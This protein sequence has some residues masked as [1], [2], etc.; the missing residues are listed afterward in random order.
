MAN[1][2]MLSKSISTSVQ[3][4]NL[5]LE[6]QLLFTWMI[7]HADDDGRLKGEPE[8]IKAIVFP[9]KEM[10]VKKVEEL[11]KELKKQELIYYWEKFN[12]KYIEFPSWLS[13]QQI[14]KDRYTPSF[15][16]PYPSN[17]DNQSE[18]TGRQQDYQQSTQYSEIKD[19]EN[20]MNKEEE[21]ARE[22]EYEGK[23]LSLSEKYKE[24]LSKK[25]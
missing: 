24:I 4:N 3:V 14:R 1:R 18:T 12:K 23:P 21:N 10:T 22:K 13:H 15:L 2:R 11:L 8:Y 9:M 6:A 17:N 7:A 5:S 16:P 20:Q 25:K 19:K